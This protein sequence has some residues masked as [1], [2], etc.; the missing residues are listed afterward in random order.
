MCSSSIPRPISAADRLRAAALGLATAAFTAVPTLGPLIFDTS[1]NTERYD[2][3]ITP[4]GHAFIVWAPIFT[5]CLA[6]TIDAARP[7]RQ[8]TKPS[9]A[10]GWPPAGA[11]ALNSCCSVA[12]QT[13]NFRY[14]PFLLLSATG[15][16]FLAHQELQAIPAGH[17]RLVGTSTV[18]LL[19][20]TSLATTGNLSAL[21]KLIN[22]DAAT[23]IVTLSK[24]A[25]AATAAGAQPLRLRLA[26]QRLSRS[27]AQQPPR[28][29]TESSAA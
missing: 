13:D 15:L 3:V 12:A 14:T 25:A 20:W 26:H 10:T 1:E 18:P 8:G 22:I 2:T 5:S 17:G 24:L 4:P 11:Y 27:P 7:N 16:T 21:T 29:P 23:K 28:N 19:G 6:S 9:T